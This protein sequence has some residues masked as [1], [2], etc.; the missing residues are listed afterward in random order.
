MGNLQFEKDTDTTPTC[1]S[2]IAPAACSDSHW[3]MVQDCR[4]EGPA[5]RANEKESPAKHLLARCRAQWPLA[6]FLRQI[7]R[8]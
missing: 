6:A 3:S 8:T 5:H 2:K 1:Q 7:R 4:E